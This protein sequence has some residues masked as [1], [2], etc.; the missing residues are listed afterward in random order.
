MVVCVVVAYAT[1]RQ[2]QHNNNN[3]F[4]LFIFKDMVQTNFCKHPEVKFIGFLMLLCAGIT[5]LSLWISFKYSNLT[6]RFINFIIF[7]CKNKITKVKVKKLKQWSQSAGNFI[8]L[9]SVDKSTSETLS[10]KSEIKLISVHVPTHLKPV[11]EDDFGHYLA[12]LIDGDGHFSKTP[13]LVI[14]FNE[15]DVALAYYI[16]S[17]IGYGNVYKVKNKK[18][19]ILVVA[20]LAGITKVVNLINGKIRSQNKLDQIKNNILTN[21]NFKSIS[22]FIINK[23]DNL[24]NHWL[25]GFSDADGS[26]QIKLLSRANRI[27]VRLAFQIDQKNSEL[28][29]LIKKFLGGNIGYRKSQDT[30]YYNSTSFGSAKKVIN[31]FD[32]F[33]LLSSK[34]VN[35]LKWRKAYLIIQNKEHLTEPGL[36]KISKIKK[37]LNRNKETD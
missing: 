30:Y 8:T 34:H 15:L 22:N 14:V 16:K 24:N 2:Q 37:T 3:I 26:F 33:H 4:I 28:L 27:E 18:A 9:T 12:G 35:Y 1:T 6:L 29:I 17:R 10:N 5:S 21:K 19:V 25:A 32:H 31:Y 7:V 11:I 13:Q 20:K 36:V 23:E